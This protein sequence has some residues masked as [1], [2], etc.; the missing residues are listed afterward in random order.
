VK[1]VNYHLVAELAGFLD[2]GADL[3]AQIELDVSASLAA[4]DGLVTR[5]VVAIEAAGPG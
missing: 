5:A 1:V 4:A 2:S 3:P